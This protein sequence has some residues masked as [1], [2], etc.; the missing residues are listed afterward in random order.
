MNEVTIY[1]ATN[2]SYCT[3]AIKLCESRDIPHTYIN[4]IHHPEAMQELTESIGQFAT[5]PQIFVDG[6]HVGGFTD[7]KD[8]LDADKG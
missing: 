5:V 8:K 1:G 4:L 2:C 3:Q 6:E 7:L